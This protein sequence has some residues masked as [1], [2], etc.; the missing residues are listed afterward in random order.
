MPGERSHCSKLSIGGS[1]NKKE[2]N[3]KNNENKNEESLAH[4]RPT[5]RSKE[6]MHAQ[7][8]VLSNGRENHEMIVDS[9]AA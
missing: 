7:P 2:Q 9:G 1:E 8:S 4:V 6:Y 3:A 5:A